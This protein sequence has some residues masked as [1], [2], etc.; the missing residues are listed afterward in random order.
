MKFKL[1]VILLFVVFT[2]CAYRRSVESRAS[3]PAD[4]IPYRGQKIKLSKAYSDFDDYKDD[5]NNILPSETERV[6]KLVM[7]A[8]IAHEFNSLDELSLAVMD[9]AFPGYG[10]GGFREEKQSDGSTLA[11]C[12]IEIP[13][14]EKSRYFA[15]RGVGGKY[16]LIDDFVAPE[17]PSIDEVRDE[18]GQLVYSTSNG[19]KVLTRSLPK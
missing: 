13:R 4:E 17:F 18:N 2:S 14:A 19:Q 8:P 7:E 15:F 16:R 3:S 1:L 10:S 6:Q 5:P 12:M 9:L 11:L